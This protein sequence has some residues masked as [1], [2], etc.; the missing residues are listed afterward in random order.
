M[1]CNKLVASL[2]FSCYLAAHISIKYV[3]YI[4]ATIARPARP[5]PVSS[6]T[7]VTRVTL[8]TTAQTRGTSVNMAP[9]TWK[10]D[11]AGV[12]NIIF[13]FLSNYKLLQVPVGSWMKF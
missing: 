13:L 2:S 1:F 7:L 12:S 5:V 3:L 11:T 8:S 6:R 9:V 10:P 4:A